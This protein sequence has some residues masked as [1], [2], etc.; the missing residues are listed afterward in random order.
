MLKSFIEISHLKCI[1]KN[2]TKNKLD[3]RGTFLFLRQVKTNR[4]HHTLSKVITVTWRKELSRHTVLATKSQTH[5][6]IVT[7]VGSSEPLH[8]IT[9]RLATGAISDPLSV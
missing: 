2:K 8:S 6:S 9:C 4:V 1:K 3:L 5:A 7:Y